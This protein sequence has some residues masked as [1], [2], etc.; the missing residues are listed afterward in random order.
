[1]AKSKA[2]VN[3]DAPKVVVPVTKKI[4][5]PSP[6]AVLAIVPTPT[7]G[8]AILVGEP[9]YYLP[10]DERQPEMSLR[11]D[12]FFELAESRDWGHGPLGLEAVHAKGHMGKNVLIAIADTGIDVGH[13]DLKDRIRPV[14]N[15]DF[16]NSPSGFMD[17]QGHGSHCAGIA[18]A[19]ANGAGLIGAAPD[20]HLIAVKVLNDQGSGASSWIAA[21]IRYAADQGVDIISLSLGGPS[22]DPNTRSAIQYA[23]SKGCWVVCAAG[24]DGRETN[25]Y[26]GHYAESIAVAALDNQSKRASFSTINVENDVAAPGVSIMSTLPDN[27]YGQMSGTSMATPY[28]AGCLA[29]LR[30]AY[31]AANKHPCTQQELNAAIKQY[32]KDIPPEGTDKWT[33]G[34][35]LDVG[36]LIEK[37]VGSSPAPPTPPTPPPGSD[38]VLKAGEKVTVRAA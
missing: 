3:G 11:A 35:L 32:S 28:V 6:K 36:K 21:G 37:L 20:A 33:G 4:P 29:C 24:N 31:K 15:K 19:S 30:G 14:G 25:N 9:I 8:D 27:R 22:A 13:P 17:Q 23:I 5:T 7:I 1:M 10:P 16:T 2:K 12:K 34:G 38:V 18:A 26:P